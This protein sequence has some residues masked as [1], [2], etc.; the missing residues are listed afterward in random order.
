MADF[1]QKPPFYREMPE[2]LVPARSGR[3][4]SALYD[5][6]FALNLGNRSL[7]L[8]NCLYLNEFVVLIKS[9]L[10]ASK[11]SIAG[12]KLP[13][14]TG[15]KSN[16]PVVIGACD[17]ILRAASIVGQVFLSRYGQSKA[18]TA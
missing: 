18:N 9:N 3:S 13:D 5:R 15:G 17:N 8:F 7:L 4:E 6:W 10:E 12:Y 2:R 11:N 16:N 1:F 14:C